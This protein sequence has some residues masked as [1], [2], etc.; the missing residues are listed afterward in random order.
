MKHMHNLRVFWQINE[1]DNWPQLF[2]TC[3]TKNLS[4][5]YNY[6]KTDDVRWW[7][8]KINKSCQLTFD[9]LFMDV[10]LKVKYVRLL[11]MIQHGRVKAKMSCFSRLSNFPMLICTF[12][13]PVIRSRCRNEDYLASNLILLI[14]KKIIS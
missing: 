5:I 7:N 2:L 14:W 4:I 3:N 10:H 6:N 11:H 8:R 9:E 1:N 13:C 12:S